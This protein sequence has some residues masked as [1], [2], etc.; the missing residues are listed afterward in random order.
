MQSN[1]DDP[2]L[3]ETVGT[4][5]LDKMPADSKWRVLLEV[6]LAAKRLNFDDASRK[7]LRLA[8]DSQPTDPTIWLE[9][10]KLEEE[11]GMMGDCLVSLNLQ[12]PHVSVRVGNR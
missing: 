5:F 4:D 1:G 2:D 9:R 3:L 8:S 11:C 7:W 10:V 6:G 12:M